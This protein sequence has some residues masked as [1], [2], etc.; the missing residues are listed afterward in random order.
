MMANPSYRLPPDRAEVM[1]RYLDALAAD[2]RA[3]DLTGIYE[4]PDLERR[5]V[6]E[7]LELLRLLEDRRLA[8]ANASMLDVGSGGGVPGI[9]IAVARP[10]IFVTLLEGSTR[11]AAWLASLSE[12][13]GLGCRVLSS[14]AE[15][16]GRIPKHRG[17]YDLVI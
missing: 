15:V 8:P 3:L 9:P 1:G 7:S 17:Q 13:L 6:V 10:D 16:A 12:G 14:R 5:A 11:K 4:R 2:A